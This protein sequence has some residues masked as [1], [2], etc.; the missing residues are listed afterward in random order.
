MLEEELKVHKYLQ[1]VLNRFNDENMPAVEGL[2]KLY[3]LDSDHAIKKMAYMCSTAKKARIESE[4][5]EKI[6]S[7]FG[8]GDM[9]RRVAQQGTEGGDSTKADQWLARIGSRSVLS[10]WPTT[11]WK[12]M[13]G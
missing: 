13:H 7:A 9:Q 10:A 6:K 2:C 11:E 4:D 12:G 8:T 3:N 1:K 5:V